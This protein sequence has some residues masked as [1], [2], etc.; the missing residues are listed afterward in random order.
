MSCEVEFSA[1]AFVKLLL[2]ASRFPHCAVNGVLLSECSEGDAAAPGGGCVCVS[3]CVP[4]FHSRLSLSAMTEVAL[5]QI[6][7][8]CSRKQQRIVGYYHANASLTDNSP[9][10]VALKI[11][12]KIAEQFSNAV[13]VM[14]EN[15]KV[16]L[17]Y[18][19]PPVILYEKKDSKWILK[20]KNLVMWRRWEETKRVADALSSAKAYDQLVDFDCHLDDIRQDWTN[21]DIN[22][23]IVE[24]CSAANGNL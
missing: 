3:D 7:I 14:V 11:G 23:K 18:G 10:T 6:D 12:D 5:Q 1:L 21:R 8:W 9:S 22:A 20:D 2:H 16:S 19:T 15:S 24:L 4:L 17:H 13:L